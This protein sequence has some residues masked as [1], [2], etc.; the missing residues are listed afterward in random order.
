MWPIEKSFERN[1]ESQPWC[2]FLNAIPLRLSIREIVGD[3][4]PLPRWWRVPRK[5]RRC[6]AN[7]RCDQ[8]QDNL[9]SKAELVFLLVQLPMPFR[10]LLRLSRPLR[11]LWWRHIISNSM[12]CKYLPTLGCQFN[13]PTSYFFLR[14][15]SLRPHGLQNFGL[16][17]KG[18]SGG[19][20]CSFVDFQWGITRNA[21]ISILIY[22]S[23]H[24]RFCNLSYVLDTHC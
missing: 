14:I 4:I 6:R 10:S 16:K 21:Y 20:S 1:L 3:G 13:N 15:S 17:C 11:N 7:V 18:A 24:V 9:Y 2:F 8:K 19:L 23:S 12:Y 22:G 5:A